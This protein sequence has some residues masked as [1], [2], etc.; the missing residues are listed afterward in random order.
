M[1]NW[2]YEKNREKT[3]M[4]SK[5]NN[6]AAP[7]IETEMGRA[8]QRRWMRMQ[9]NQKPNACARRK[10]KRRPSRIKFDVR[11]LINWSSLAASVKK[12]Y[13]A[14]IRIPIGGFRKPRFLE[15]ENSYYIYNGRATIERQP[16]CP[17][18]KKMPYSLT[19]CA[20]CGQRFF[21]LIDSEE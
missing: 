11:R 12:M 16:I 18:C 5:S 2:K 20:F 1:G 4:I 3:S 19:Q 21:K 8:W 14:L 7:W 10:R 17:Y 15:W 9:K 6:G 13:R